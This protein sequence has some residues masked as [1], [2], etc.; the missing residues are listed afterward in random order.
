MSSS[1]KNDQYHPFTLEAAAPWS[2]G[3]AEQGHVLFYLI[4]VLC[5]IQLIGH[6]RLLA[7]KQEHI[8]RITGLERKET[9]VPI[10]VGEA[11][12]R[13]ASTT[14]AIIHMRTYFPDKPLWSKIGQ[15]MAAKK[16]KK[17]PFSAS[18]QK[19]NF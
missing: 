15:I 12:T 10:A 7:I 5:S 13:H 4:R 3:S 14:V 19:R 8:I 6:G 18:V 9:R 16:N 17:N 2:F 1:S 11:I